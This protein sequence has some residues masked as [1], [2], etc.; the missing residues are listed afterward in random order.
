MEFR[1]QGYLRAYHLDAGPAPAVSFDDWW[2]ANGYYNW[3]RIRLAEVAATFQPVEKLK[4]PPTAQNVRDTLREGFKGG[5]SLA[6]LCLVF[7]TAE[8]YWFLDDDAAIREAARIP[9]QRTMVVSE[10]EAA[11][12]RAL[13]E[14][15]AA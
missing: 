4:A 5:I 8:A 14:T 3:L 15:E 9:D 13:R 2:T 1:D 6:S 11:K 12:I 10:A 7:K